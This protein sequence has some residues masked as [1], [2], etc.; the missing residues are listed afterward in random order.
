[1]NSVAISEGDATAEGFVLPSREAVRT[2]CFAMSSHLS[3]K[4]I[5]RGSTPLRFWWLFTYRVFKT[6]LYRVQ[7]RWISLTMSY[8]GSR[9]LPV[10]VMVVM[11]PARMRA[12]SLSAHRVNVREWGAQLPVV[13]FLLHAFTTIP[14]FGASRAVQI[15]QYAK[16]LSMGDLCRRWEIGVLLLTCIWMRRG[17]RHCGANCWQTRA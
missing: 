10:S 7:L 8:S 13:Q 5:W 2:Y 16:K 3:F 11:A 9:A 12:C 17:R 1:M 14:R 6:M 15:F 4:N